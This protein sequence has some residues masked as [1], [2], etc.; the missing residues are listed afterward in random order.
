MSLQELI[1]AAAADGEIHSRDWEREP[2]P[3]RDTP[4]DR[5]RGQLGGGSYERDGRE[6]SYER[7]RS[8]R[9]RSRSRESDELVHVKAQLRD[10]LERGNAATAELERSKFTLT[11]QLEDVRDELRGARIALDEEQQR[12]IR[13]EK[14]SAGLETQVTAREDRIVELENLQRDALKHI[15]EIEE[16]AK[17]QVE[18]AKE[19]YDAARLK[20]KQ[21]QQAM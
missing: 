21:E 6:R 7:E 13:N 3:S 5:K 11:S 15:R 2:M 4:R 1:D 9:R 19:G 12:A 17:L 10:A 20:L 8:G 18:A 14:R 16:K